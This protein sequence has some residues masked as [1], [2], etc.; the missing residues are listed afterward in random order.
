MKHR[1]GSSKITLTIIISV[2][3][4]FLSYTTIAVLGIITFG[5]NEI[6]GDLMENYNALDPVVLAGIIILLAKTIT[7]Y[8]LILFCGRLAVEDFYYRILGFEENASHEIYSRII[9]V[10]IWVL[11]TIA[12]AIFIPTISVAIDFLGSFTVLFVF[13][14]PGMCFLSSI[15]YKDPYIYLRKDKIYLFLAS[16][17]IVL[18]IFIFGLTFTQTMR[19]DFINDNGSNER[20]QLCV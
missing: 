6:A 15:L 20:V 14:F 1:I 4:C 5:S 2:L 10:L 16:L 8:P 19:K 17:Y 9:I 12:A 11:T 13:I 18:G 3:I 7:I